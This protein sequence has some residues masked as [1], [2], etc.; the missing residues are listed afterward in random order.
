MARLRAEGWILVA[1][2]VVASAL[3]LL[4]NARVPGPP[5][6]MALP[7]ASELVEMERY[8][9]P[10]DAAVGTQVGIPPRVEIDGSPFGRVVVPV[11]MDGPAGPPG[12]PAPRWVVSAIMIAGERRVAI[13]NDE[14][15]RPGERLPDGARAVEIGQNYIV[16]ETPEGERRRLELQR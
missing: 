9:D 3:V 1:A 6:E 12:E 2:V 15:V 4:S 8:L 13:V 16:L 5:R 14:L 11:G 7:T 10:V